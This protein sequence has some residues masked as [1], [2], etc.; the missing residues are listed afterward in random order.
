MPE[1]KQQIRNR[2]ADLN[3][4]ATQETGIVEELSQHLED[5]YQELLSSGA[6]SRA[7]YQSVL[8]ELSENELLTNELRRLGRS[9]STEPIVP[10]SDSGTNIFVG[11][12]QDFRYGLRTLRKNPL[13]T[14]AVVVTLALGVGANTIMF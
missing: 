14:V 1:W 11:L 12:W 7:A 6:D 2:L 5:R 10:G 8:D 4:P 3:L 9:N 13:F